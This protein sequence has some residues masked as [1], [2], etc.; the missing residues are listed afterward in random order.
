MAYLLLDEIRAI[1]A[2]GRQFGTLLAP[3]SQ[4]AVLSF[5]NLPI[6]H[7]FFT[8]R[9]SL[10]ESLRGTF[11]SGRGCPIHSSVSKC[12]GSEAATNHRVRLLPLARIRA[13]HFMNDVVGYPNCPKHD[14][15]GSIFRSIPQATQATRGIL[16]VE[17][18]YVLALRLGAI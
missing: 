16:H 12:L 9:R 17:S 1:R 8:V 18:K 10:A 15:V 5:F 4:G 11:L 6:P 7:V 2:S 14:C 13:Y 3:S